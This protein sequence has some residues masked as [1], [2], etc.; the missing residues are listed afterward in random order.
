VQR[1][2]DLNWAESRC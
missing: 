1:L 2:K